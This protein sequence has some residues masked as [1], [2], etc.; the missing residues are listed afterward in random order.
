MSGRSNAAF[1]LKRLLAISLIRRLSLDLDMICLKQFQGH[2]TP[3]SVNNTDLKLAVQS[4]RA[5]L[6]TGAVLIFVDCV[7]NRWAVKFVGREAT[8]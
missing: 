3:L 4:K 2:G 6:K 7:G 5:R 8:Q 1:G